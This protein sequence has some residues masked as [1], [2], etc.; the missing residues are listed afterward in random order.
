VIHLAANIDHN[1]EET[2][3]T[4]LMEVKPKNKLTGLISQNN[5]LFRSVYFN[6]DELSIFN[7]DETDDFENRSKL[8][9]TT[10][11]RAKKTLSHSLSFQKNDDNANL[12]KFAKIKYQQEII[13]K[14]MFL[15][16]NTKDKLISDCSKNI[17]NNEDPAFYLM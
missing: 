7:K 3:A 6:R 5:H 16:A 10:T 1:V 2:S 11:V 9:G 17:D 8:M 13:I 12:V 4:K 15:F 14:T